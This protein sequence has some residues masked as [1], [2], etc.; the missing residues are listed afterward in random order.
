MSMLPQEDRDRLLADLASMGSSGRAEGENKEAFPKTFL[1]V[2]EHARAFDPDVVLIVGERGSGKSELFRAVVELKLLDS[3]VRRSR[4]SKVSSQNT[5]WLPGHPLHKEFPNAAGLR[6]FVGAN[7]SD[8]EA[9][10]DLWFAYL[11]RVLHEHLPSGNPLKGSD[12]LSLPGAEVDKI[13]DEFRKAGS[14]PLVILDQLDN[15]LEREGR[16]IFVS[17]DE[18][19]ILGS[20]DWEA[21][22]RAIQGL[23]S[24][25]AEHSRRWSRI[26][27]KLFLRTDLFRRHWQLLG[28]DLSKLAA[29]RAE[30]SWSDRNLYAMLVKRIANGSEALK[31]YCLSS[32]LRFV[33]D[34]QLGLIPQMDKAEDARSLIERMAGQY[35]GANLK[36]GST[37]R[38]LL[39]HVR[40]GNGRAMPRA[41]V[42][43][44]EEAAMQEREVQRATQSRL[45]N[46]VSL[47]RA[48]DKV[49]EEHVLQANIS[50]LPWLP[51]VAD[52]LR[53][54]GVPMER[55][56]A[57]KDLARDWDKDW[58]GQSETIRPPVDKPSEL[59]DYL[60]EIGVFRL[61]PEGRIDVPDLF[62]NGLGM[63]RKGGV[64]KH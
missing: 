14:Q 23:I 60:V 33:E 28:A 6:R 49:S 50:E 57:E 39:T 35:M 12:L 45:L 55:R 59:V 53:G 22:G 41:L 4:L 19:D 48:L 5:V 44:I 3:I 29:N 2:A 56:F 21:M 63:T 62:L 8:P 15:R 58:S 9:I 30:I 26:R 16:W 54:K 31:K 20:Y 1:P 34:P 64:A 61:R 47:R 32:R 36:K 42:R 18:L 51:G 46:P 25:W 40:D 11:L 27:A 10:Q 17:Y 52:R 37:F 7:A 24:F 38:W 43:L 13:V